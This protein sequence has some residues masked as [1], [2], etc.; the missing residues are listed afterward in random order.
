MG[1][2]L[3]VVSQLGLEPGQAQGGVTPDPLPHDCGGVTPAGSP[4]PACCAY[5]YVYYDGLPVNGADVTVHSN[6]GLLAT[7][8]GYGPASSFPYYGVDLS[9]KPLRVSVGETITVS[10]GYWG[11]TG[12]TVHSVGEAGQQVDVV[13]LGP[14]VDLTVPAITVD[15]ANPDPGQPITV[16]ITILN[17]GDANASGFYTYLYID[18]ED[19]P[20]DVSTPDTSYTYIF[21]LS[22]GRSYQWSYTDYTFT[23]GCHPIWAW[24]DR[25]NDVTESDEGNNQSHVVVCAGQQ[26]DPDDYEEDDACTDAVDIPNDGTHQIHNLCPV[27]D[28]DWV[29]FQATAGVTYTI[30]ASNV[31]PDAEII[32]YLYDEC[33]GAP[34]FGTGARIVWQAQ[35]SG[36][37]YVKVEHH[38]QTYGPDTSYELSVTG[39]GDCDDYEPDGNCALARDIPIDGTRQTHVFC[40]EG[41]EDWVKFYAQSGASYLI[42][43]D[44]PGADA[45]PILAL[46]D[47]CEAGPSLGHGQQIFWTATTDGMYYLQVVN[48]DPE[49][50]GPTT[51]YDLRVEEVGGCQEDEYESDD[52]STEANSIQVDGASQR[53]NFCPAGDHDWVK[54]NAVAGTEYTLETSNLASES[55][56]V[57]CLYD[58]DGTTQIECD[59]DGGEGEASHIVWQSPSA[60]TY[61]ARV[62]HYC[63][64]ASGPDTAYDLSVTSKQCDPDGYEEDDDSATART[65]GTNGSPQGHN[66]CGTADKDWVKFTPSVGLTYIIQTSNLGPESDTMLTLYDTDRTTQ[67]A[68]NDDYGEGLDS[69]ID[70]IFS[71]AGTY[72]VKS[73]HFDADRYGAGTEYQLSVG[74]TPGCPKPLSEVQIV[75]PSSGYTDTPYAF[76]SVIAPP[77]ATTPI[78]YTWSPEPDSGQ[79]TASASYQWGTPGDYTINLMAENC[80]GAVSDSH[81]IDIRSPGDSQVRT[82][83]L[84][85]RE[86]LAALYGQ[87]AAQ[88]VMGKLEQL[89][90]HEVVDGQIV[91]VETNASV[92][93]A[94]SDWVAD[95]LNTTKANNVASAVRNLVMATLENNPHVE[96]ILI[97]GNDEVIPFRR[98]LDRTSYPESNYESS[99]STDTTPR[100]ACRDD[101][102][103]TDDYYADREPSQER[104]HEIYIPDYATGRLIETPNEI[105]AI[106]DAFL[107]DD[108]VTA[109]KV[110]VTGYDFIQPEAQQMCDVW[111]TDL[112]SGHVDCELLGDGWTG[113]QLKQ[114]QVNT[115]PRYDVQSIN[116]HANHR[117]EGAPSWGTVSADDIATYGESDLSR[118][119]IYTLGCHSG[120]N[121]V[122]SDS[123][124]QNGLDLAQA[125]A[126]RLAN[127]VANT[128]FGWG[129]GGARCLSEELM[130]DYTQD[131]AR[132]SSALIGKGLLSAKQ[133]YYREDGDIDGYDEKILIEST[134]YGLPMYE[135]TTGGTLEEE[136]PFPSVVITSTSPIA[137][138]PF[139]QGSLDFSLVGALGA[140]G[141][142]ETTDGTY[143]S[144]DGHIQA[145]AGQPVQPEFFADVSV[146]EA[147][148]ARGAVLTGG[149]YSVQGDFD[150]VIAQPVNEY[151]APAEPSFEFVGW[152]P[153]LPF[154]LRGRGT[155]FTTSET[156]VTAMGQYNSSQGSERLYESMSFDLY[157]SD[158][159]DRTPP[160]ITSVSARRKGM[161]LDFKVG[162]S[163]PSSLHRVVVAYT[164]GGGSWSALDLSYD[165]ARAK[166]TG[167]VTA[168]AGIEWFVQAVDGAG[169]VGM[170]SEKGPYYTQQ[171]KDIYRVYLPLVSKVHAQ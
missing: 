115:T 34:S 148:A 32:L 26:C 84:V 153:A 108:G 97:V 151:Y 12:T 130:Y 166:W 50:Y 27:G 23:Q 120:F 44:R 7:A 156:L 106:I 112:G 152:Y 105:L 136:E 89:A 61:Y 124:G 45:E 155:V 10:A 86:R 72:Y 29:K 40:Y 66:F 1:L 52:S 16:T 59:D 21:G 62:T 39:G 111:R 116:G 126:R 118:A 14:G 139:S 42:V 5:G 19:E 92:A 160:E 43:A 71:S 141:E 13:T 103:L 162:A 24:V 37:Y 56:T 33:G 109:N 47:S 30:E 138:G 68:F 142:I 128:G 85:N 100:A 96:Y 49:V 63:E 31:G 102:S 73:E 159:P 76:T 46:H 146:P 114:K 110:L 125:F 55:D 17:Q 143:F 67:L 157:Y 8:T 48:H 168:G 65:I 38:D 135:L 104:G 132:G 83:V 60:G 164:N 158:S 123:V 99:A 6:H 171:A 137:F 22:A 133:R 58:T 3:I 28:V 154:A 79:G 69:R 82:L 70:Y 163:D 41:D 127:Y 94:Y 15:P 75:G 140:F 113:N 57:L 149:S 2:T 18:P 53:H 80:G 161:R 78:I 88:Q 11:H 165:S 129:C 98:V 144:L 150:P 25:G 54:F 35:Q 121:D 107:S 170:A 134:L 77:D 131:L 74:G 95:P 87:T 167:S 117:V 145:N 91:Q 119:L 147:G 36:T 9:S 51:N 64:S 4:T 93:T 169:N 122:G 90:R 81:T 101:M 20:P